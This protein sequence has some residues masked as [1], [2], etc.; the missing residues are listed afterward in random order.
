MA[1]NGQDG[2]LGDYPG[3]KQR[4]VSYSAPVSLDCAD[5]DLVAVGWSVFKLKSDCAFS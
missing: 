1:D 4:C 5:S 3:N 2:Y